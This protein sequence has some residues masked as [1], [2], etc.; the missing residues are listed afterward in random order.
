MRECQYKASPDT[1]VHDFLEPKYLNRFHVKLL[2]IAIYE[3]DC[4]CEIKILNGV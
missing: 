4:F 2:F 1:S 3:L